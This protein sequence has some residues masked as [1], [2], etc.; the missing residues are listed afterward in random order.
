MNDN[1]K[2][3]L[4][5]PSLLSEDSRK[6]R[7]NLMVVSVACLLVG[8]TEQLPTKLSTLGI[9][10]DAGTQ[11]LI[12]LGL[13]FVGVYFWM[14]FFI[15]GWLEFLQWDKESSIAR[16]ISELYNDDDAKGER[17]STHD[18]AVHEV[19]LL[20]CAYADSYSISA[21]YRHHRAKETVDAKLESLSFLIR[22]R[23]FFELVMPL[24]LALWGLYKLFPIIVF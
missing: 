22:A 11:N 7:R 9:T 10:F 3:P 8:Y 14:Y 17:I 18:Q 20:E 23:V 6:T 13:F 24:L 16:K 15:C 1:S 2:E 19:E 12:G 21:E 5:F 4:N